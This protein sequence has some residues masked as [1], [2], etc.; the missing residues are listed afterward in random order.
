MALEQCIKDSLNTLGYSAL[1]GYQ[2]DVTGTVHQRFIEHTRICCSPWISARRDRCTRN[3][4]FVSTPTGSGKSLTFEIAPFIL[5]FKRYR[6]LREHGKLD[7]ILL[8][9][10]P[11]VGLMKEQVRQLLH[12]GLKAVYISADATDMSSMESGQFN[13]VF[14]SP[15]AFLVRHRM[16]LLTDVYRSRLA[17]IFVD[18]S[19]WF[20]N[21]QQMFDLYVVSSSS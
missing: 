4:V 8:I 3:N 20:E 12:R 16:L 15:K 17:T 1:R 18:E 9:I 6:E 7:S 5:D 13:Y 21:G 10:S 2:R 19:H 11:L 14:G